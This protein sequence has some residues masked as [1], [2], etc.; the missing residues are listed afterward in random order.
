MSGDRERLRQTFGTVAGLYDRA[1]PTYPAELFD[2][3]VELTGLGP[4]ARILEIGSGTGQATRALAER[5]FRVTCVEL[6][7]DL[8]AVARRNL[9]DLDQVEVVNANFEEWEPSEPGFDA[10]AAFSSFHWIDPEVRYRK[11]AEILVPH[12]KL[13]IVGAIHVQPSDGDPFFVDVQ[14]DYE[15]VLPDDPGTQAA[16]DGPPKPETVADLR[17]EI[18]GSGF[19]RLVG[20]PR[21]VW[22]VTYTAESYLELLS[23][24]SGHIALDAARRDD[25]LARIRRRIES[26]SGGRVRKSY[27]SILNVA[28]SC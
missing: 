14:R 19:F 5:G 7:S 1:R 10:V 3:L 2:G 16:V 28:E 27:L 23:T 18:E 11:C 8:A 15:A 22:D 9:A 26:R 6:G 12:G 25:L 13:I 4:G 21:Y 20:S 24:N 17:D